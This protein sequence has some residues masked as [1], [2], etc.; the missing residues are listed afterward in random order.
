GTATPQCRGVVTAADAVDAG[1]CRCLIELG[2]KPVQA[3]LPAPPW[4]EGI[5]LG[6]GVRA[7]LGVYSCQRG[8]GSAAE[9]HK[10]GQGCAAGARLDHRAQLNAF[11]TAT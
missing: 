4:L 1:S 9:C 5:S 3:E 8:T 7:D 6:R 2:L 10:A 11:D